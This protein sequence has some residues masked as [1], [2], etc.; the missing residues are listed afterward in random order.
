[1]DFKDQVVIVTGGASGM[2]AASS[3]LFAQHGAKVVLVDRQA[4]LAKTVAAEIGGLAIPGDVSQSAFCDSVLEQTQSQF[5]RLDVLVNAAGIIVRAKGE[6]TSDEAWNRI[7]G[8]NV[9]GTFFMCRAAIRAMKPRGGGAIVNFGSIWGDLGAAGVAAY[10][11]SKG[12]VHNLTRALALDHA[13]DGIRI[14]AVCPGEVNTPMIQSERSEAVTPELMQRLADSVPVGRL[15]DPSEI[16]QM[17][18]FLAS[19]RASYM[20]GSL[21]LVDGAFAAR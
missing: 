21:V 16:G 5:G 3:R 6:D 7:M 11:A 12:A 9:S 13:K 15:A 18:L 2:G 8:V 17:V 4:E 19:S 10:C 1:M 20:T 14:N